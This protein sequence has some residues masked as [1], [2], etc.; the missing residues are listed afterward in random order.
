MCAINDNSQSQNKQSTRDVFEPSQW[1]H[2]G[3]STACGAAPAV[4]LPIYDRRGSTSDG[5]SSFQ[6]LY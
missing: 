5:T 3:I 4:V 1:G 6:A 2:C